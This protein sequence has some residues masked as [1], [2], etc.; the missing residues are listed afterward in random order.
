MRLPGVGLHMNAFNKVATFEAQLKQAALSPAL[1]QA[2]ERKARQ[3]KRY[4]AR[5]FRHASWPYCGT[6]HMARIARQVAAGS[7]R[8]ENGLVLNPGSKCTAV[9]CTNRIEE[10]AW[11]YGAMCAPCVRSG[12]GA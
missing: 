5:S 3:A 9:D 12:L 2:L 8:P 10:G 4:K 1:R 7:L 6:R 11:N